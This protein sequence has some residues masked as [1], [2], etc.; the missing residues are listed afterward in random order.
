[1]L[2][3]YGLKTL[4]VPTIKPYGGSTSSILLTELTTTKNL[5]VVMLDC[6]VVPCPVVPCPVATLNSKAKVTICLDRSMEHPSD[7]AIFRHRPYRLQP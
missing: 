4:Y 7:L 2:A 1:M 6:P 3:M 5:T